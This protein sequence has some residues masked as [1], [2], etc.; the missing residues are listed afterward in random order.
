[1]GLILLPAVV[2]LCTIAGIGGGGVVIPFCMLLFEFNTK[3][4]ITI[5][6][7]S[8]LTCSITRFLMTM[9]HQHP[10]KDA[11]VIDYGLATVML[12]TV[13]MGSYIGVLMNLTVP[14]LLLQIVLT[15]LLF[16]MCIQ[17]SLKARQIFKRE[18]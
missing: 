3:S 13:M 1:M 2:A 18:T 15:V 7:F 17:S 9:K 12:P 4:A 16:A 11:V 5:S 8:M 6:G 14:T 10:E